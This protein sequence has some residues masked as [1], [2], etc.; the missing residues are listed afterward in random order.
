M[1]KNQNN[2]KINSQ[3][4]QKV[5]SRKKQKVNGKNKQKL[6][7]QNR[8]K[9][10][11]QNKQNKKKVIRQDEQSDIIQNNKKE[12]RKNIKGDINQRKKKDNSELRSN[13]NKNNKEIIN[14]AYVM[15]GLFVITL[16]YFVFFMVA[17]RDEVINNTYNKRQDL[18]AEQI[19]RGSILTED[20]KTLAHTIVSEDKEERRVY[21]Y[22]D[23]FAHVVGRFSHGRTGL[24]LSENFHLLTSNNNSLQQIFLELT[25]QKK[26]GDNI[27]TTLNYD[28]QRTAYDALGNNKG[29]V[30]VM[31]PSSGK[32]LAMVSKPAY[33]P[34]NIDKIWDDIKDDN[35]NKPLTNRV[36]QEAYP[37]GSIFKIVTLLE[38]IKENPNYENYSYECTGKYTGRFGQI[39]CS[40]PHGKL[41]LK[42]SFA[43]SCNTSFA[44]IG[45]SLDPVKFKGLFD[46]LNLETYIPADIDYNHPHT[47]IGQGDVSVSPM[48]MALITAAIANG[49]VVMK[50]YLVDHI[51]TGDGDV[52]K[53]FLPQMQDTYITAKEAGILTEYMAEVVQSGTAS[54]LKNN[55]YSVAG[56]TGT[57][58]NRIDSKEHSWFVGFSNTDN[59]D[60]IV[61]IIVENAGSGRKH[62]V[63]IAKEI[64]DAYYK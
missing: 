62:A 21:P 32:I 9:V 29:A 12:S 13:L 42:E 23:M 27:V 56:K 43:Q 4:K 58:Q 61:S 57:A 3:N 19:V 41:N 11:N 7:R 20:E 51:E 44:N 6:N 26:I 50:P 47:A 34:N 60:I 14:I 31:E 46:S 49:G 33:D 22:G 30:L 25:G 38:Y 5:D 28:L 36:S 64:F 54:S 15:I 63:P 35:V 52:V 2:K 40:K 53:K 59:P 17:K 1:K 55:K 45:E 16:G 8:E 18:L 10:N 48:Q 37:P 39:T 24:E